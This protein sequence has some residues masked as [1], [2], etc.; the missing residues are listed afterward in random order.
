MSSVGENVTLDRSVS[1][2]LKAVATSATPL[3]VKLFNRCLFPRTSTNAAGVMIS[4]PAAW[5]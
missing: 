5:S 3:D 1:S 2:A 4:R